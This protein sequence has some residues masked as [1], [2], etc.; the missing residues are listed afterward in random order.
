MSDNRQLMQ[1]DR[2]LDREAGFVAGINSFIDSVQERVTPQVP[3]NLNFAT[4]ESNRPYSQAAKEN[5]DANTPGPQGV[6]TSS[7]RLTTHASAAAAAASKKPPAKMSQPAKAPA[8]S[9]LTTKQVGGDDHDMNDRVHGLHSDNL[10]LKEKEN[11]LELEIK[12]MQTKLHRIDELMTKVRGGASAT[13]TD[14]GRL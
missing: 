5:S 10:R 8:V 4:G 1:N 11:L 14:F 6:I 9:F 7:N 3:Q 12:K 2:P 13:D